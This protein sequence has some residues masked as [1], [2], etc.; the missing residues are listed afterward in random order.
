MQMSI[1]LACAQSDSQVTGLAL[2][3]LLAGARMTAGAGFAG[4]LA[5]AAAVINTLSGAF[6]KALQELTVADSA[7]I[8]AETC[9][10]AL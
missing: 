2:A 9:G 6:V 5:G 7:C 1:W 3:G 10:T 4:A 8:S